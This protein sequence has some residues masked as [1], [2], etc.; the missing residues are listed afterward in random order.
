MKRDI[1]VIGA[2]AGGVEAVTRLVGDLPRNLPAALFITVHFP[3]RA[4]SAL[5]RILNRHGELPARHP[6]DG[7]MF[8][9]GHIYV[10]PP[11]S[12][13]LL[14]RN[15]MRLSR[16]PTENGNRP[17][18]DPMFRSAA[19]AFRNRVI[20]VVLSGSLDDGTGGLRAISRRGGV[21]VAQDPTDALF[22][23][24][25]ASAVAHGGVSHVVPIERMG[26]LL[27][28][29]CEEEIPPLREADVS[30]DAAKETE[31][32]SFDMEAIEDPDRHPGEPSPFSCPDCGGVLW[33]IPDG[34]LEHFRC[35]VGHGWT[36]NGLVEQQQESLE[37]ALWSALRALEE[38][39]AL[40]RQMAGRLGTTSKHV[41]DRF[42]MQAVEAESHAHHI[43]R[44]LLSRADD[45]APATD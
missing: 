40:N 42:T 43:R 14:Y 19:V 13:L 35:R 25:P 33:S 31:Y 37:T 24:M 39:A 15:A 6:A 41:R 4:Q 23:S 17:A 29:L 18:I 36:A 38:S 16:G 44:L 8:Q 27:V 11:D 3:R 28:R 10:A 45:A 30:D 12:H 2:S 26:G 22:P 32:S 34:D 21:G 5:P 1:I 9:P 20:G 7:E